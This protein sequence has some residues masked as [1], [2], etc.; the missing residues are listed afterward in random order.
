VSGPLAAE[1]GMN[2]RHS[3]LGSDNR[4]NATIG[5]AVRLVAGLPIIRLV[6]MIAQ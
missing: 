5:R 6:D 3:A 1:V 4:A 2:A